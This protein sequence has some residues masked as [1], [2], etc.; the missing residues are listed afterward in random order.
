MTATCR[1]EE[2]A[3]APDRSRTTTPSNLEAVPSTTPDPTPT[4]I[5]SPGPE[6]SPLRYESRRETDEVLLDDGLVEDDDGTAD[7][8]D[9]DEP[10]GF[11]PVASRLAGL[12]ILAARVVAWPGI[13]ESVPISTAQRTPRRRRAPTSATPLRP[14]PSHSGDLPPAHGRR[15]AL[16]HQR[17]G[18]A[19]HGVG[20]RAVV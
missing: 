9:A 18:L 12:G 15:I 16:W 20:G 6:A 2:G 10:T 4:P 8:D 11:L 14:Q 13:C 17:S 1:V 7:L 19:R 5:D 3:G